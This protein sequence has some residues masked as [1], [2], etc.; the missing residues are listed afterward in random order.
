MKPGAFL[1]NISRGQVVD[2]EALYAA[3]RDRKIGGAAIDVWWQY[4][5]A[6]RAQPPRLALSV[7]RI[8]ERHRDAAQF[9]LDRGMVRRRWDEVADNLGRFVR[10]EPLINIVIA[11]LRGH[12]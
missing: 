2:E 1:I 11:N 10:G 6:G 3:L 7:P 4:P 5:N 12:R 8:A 9:G